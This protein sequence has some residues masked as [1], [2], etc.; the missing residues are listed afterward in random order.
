MDKLG[1]RSMMAV[2]TFALLGLMACQPPA[3]NV[4]V[5]GGG[6]AGTVTTTTP[7]NQ[8]TTVPVNQTTTTVPGQASN[9][10]TGGLLALPTNIGTYTR[11]QFTAIPSIE[12]RVGYQL[13]CHW[14]AYAGYTAIFWGDVARAGDQIDLVVNPSQLPPGTLQGP[15][16]PAFAFHDSNFWAQGINV[17]L[18]LRF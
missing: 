14:R 4:P 5:G 13:T 7:A 11:N 6:G 1:K 3:G 17:G 2:G 9:I 16:R 18:E 10:Y 15:A 12:A 8:T